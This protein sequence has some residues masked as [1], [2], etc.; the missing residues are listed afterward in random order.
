MRSS[1]LE[2]QSLK[3]EAWPRGGSI[4]RLRHAEAGALYRSRSDQAR[5]MDEMPGS[6]C[7]SLTRI[8]HKY[9]RA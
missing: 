3:L 6:F 4:L 1:K 8:V 7:G 2:A 5:D 9:M